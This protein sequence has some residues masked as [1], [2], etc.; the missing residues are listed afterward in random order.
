MSSNSGIQV[1]IVV[2]VLL[3]AGAVWVA[4]RSSAESG[5][6]QVSAEEE[7]KKWAAKLGMDVKG[8]S[9]VKTDSDGD[10]Y[11]SCTIAT[12]DGK[13]HAVECT[14]AWTRNAGCRT[15]KLRTR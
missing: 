6:D 9:C 3:I 11:V 7:A 1:I 14:S 5:A 10:G 15:P 12:E 2:V 13:T 8:L 4:K